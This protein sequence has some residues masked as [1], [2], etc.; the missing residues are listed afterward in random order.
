M[1]FVDVFYGIC[2]YKW[3][4]EEDPSA[5]RRA[6][7]KARKKAEKQRAKAEKKRI[8]AEYGYDYYLKDNTWNKIKDQ[9]RNESY[10]MWKRRLGFYGFGIDG[11]ELKTGR[12]HTAKPLVR[13]SGTHTQSTAD[14]T[15]RITK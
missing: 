2:M 15:R 10:D 9:K 6:K 3:L 7:E 8:I 13:D 4:T 14:S 5:A 11:V 1:T 12:A